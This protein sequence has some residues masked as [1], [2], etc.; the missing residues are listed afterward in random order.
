LLLLLHALQRGLV[1]RQQLGLLGNRRLRS[2]QLRP[3][4]LQLR[5]RVLQLHLG[6]AEQHLGGGQLFRGGG[7]GGG[8]LLRSGDAGLSESGGLLRSGSGASLSSLEV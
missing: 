6:A 4:V 7:G 2:R 1:P 5:L 8:G 3:G